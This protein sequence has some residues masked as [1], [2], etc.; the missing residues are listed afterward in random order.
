M[1]QGARLL[2]IAIFYDGNFFYHVSNYYCHAHPRRAR[3]SIPGLHGFIRTMVAAQ[4]NIDERLCQIVDCHYFRGRLPAMEAKNRQL[5]LN[6]RIFDDILMNEGV[7]THYLP[8]S[9]GVEKG[10]DLSLALEALELTLFKQ[11]NII[12]LI[13]SDGDYLPLARKLNALGARVMVLGWDFEYTDNNGQ[14]RSTS[15]S[16]RLMREVSYPVR[17]NRIIDG[18][19][20]F[21]GFDASSLFV[22]PATPNVPSP[23]SE[24]AGPFDSV[25]DENRLHHDS[26]I[27][28]PGNAPSFF[29]I[30]T[31]VQLK[32]GYGFLATSQPEPKNLFFLWEDL[33]DCDFDQL[34]IGDTLQF[35]LGRNERGECAKQVRPVR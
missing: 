7:E 35:V 1:N 29:L 15:T 32:N 33:L 11:Y 25:T 10:V 31:V 16:A 6:E 3:L 14:T 26:R 9:H 8:M 28:S 34:K 19:T 21:P 12:V 13:A 24:Y 5:L 17:M 27:S 30:G 4:E 2:K 18:E 22:A 20:P 23:G